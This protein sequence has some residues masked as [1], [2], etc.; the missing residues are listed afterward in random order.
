MTEQTSSAI[1]STLIEN[2]GDLLARSAYA[3]W[4]EENRY[5][6][7]AFLQRLLVRE[8]SNSRGEAYKFGDIY[9]V[10]RSIQFNL[11]VIYPDGDV[12]LMHPYEKTDALSRAILKHKQLFS[13][14]NL[15]N[16]GG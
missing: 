16:R 3:G 10:G 6:E 5:T 4:L 13:K 15:W 1:L 12:K 11:F 7:E 8:L 9:L 14:V 2:P